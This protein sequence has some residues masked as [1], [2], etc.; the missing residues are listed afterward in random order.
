MTNPPGPSQMLWN[1][2]TIGA[3]FLTSQWHVRSEGGFA[4]SC[5]GA[6]ALA[7]TL[8]ALRRGVREYD[9][10]IA[11]DLTRRGA[12]LEAAS[13]KGE[14]PG[15]GGNHQQAR[16]GQQ[17]QQRV[18]LRVTAVQQLIR[19]A[20]HVV[21]FAVAYMVMLLAMYFNGYMIL[22]IFIGNGLGKFLCDWMSQ[23]VVLGG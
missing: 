18:T 14:A 11:R 1:W 22:C 4:A 10:Y 21:T 20:L 6:M 9:A 19:A 23:T 12:V 3:C 16:Q 2:T 8:E 17:Q 7:M 5:L 15:G 13:A